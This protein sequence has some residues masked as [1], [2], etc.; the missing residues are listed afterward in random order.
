MPASARALARAKAAVEY[1]L[2]RDFHAAARAYR[3]AAAALDVDA[4]TDGDGA[5]GLRAKAREYRDRADELEDAARATTASND[6]TSLVGV[7]SGA[8]RA[9]TTVETKT[10][11]AGGANVVAG[12]AAVGACAGFALLGPMSAVV[13]AGAMAYGTTRKD[14]V[15]SACA[16]AGKMAASAYSSVKRWNREYAVAEKATAACATGAK[17]VKKLDDEYKIREKTAAVVSGS[18]KAACEFNEKH[19]VTEKIGRGVATGLDAV[20]K[21]FGGDDASARGGGLREN[22]PLPSAPR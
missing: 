1:D 3:D 22:V 14:G 11:A 15:G 4:E 9:K 5:D 7:A 19:G 16:G 2:A 8:A 21:K 6:Y 20:T 12:A 17:A 13:A 10:R 18:A